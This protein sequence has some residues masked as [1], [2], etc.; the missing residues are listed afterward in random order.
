M[1]AQVLSFEGARVSKHLRSL[2]RRNLS[3]HGIPI[4][5]TS[6][7]YSDLE[8]ISAGRCMLGIELEVPSLSLVFDSTIEAPIFSMLMKKMR[9]RFGR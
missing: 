5:G 2:L 1:T 7:E 8:Q 9:N 6:V 4:R 3:L